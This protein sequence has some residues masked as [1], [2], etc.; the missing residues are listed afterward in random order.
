MPVFA[1]AQ[2]MLEFDKEYSGAQEP[3]GSTPWITAT[4]D[5]SF[6]DANTVRVTIE[7][8]NL[9]DKETIKNIFFNFNPSY[10]PADLVF[11]LVAANGVGFGVTDISTGLNSFKAGPAGFFDIYLD[12]PPPP[13]SDAARFQNGDSIIFDAVYTSALV[14]EDFLFAN[15]GGQDEDFVG[16]FLAAAHVI[17][18]GDD[19]EGSGWVAAVVPEPSTY[20]GILVAGMLLFI[21][22]RR[23]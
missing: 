10:D 7:G 18:I 6:G 2:I 5:D 23:R 11:N 16:Q 21:L 19:G 22:R 1:S 13:G 8:Q 4:F 17:S 9:T 14:E 20:A 12:L 3:V 15:E